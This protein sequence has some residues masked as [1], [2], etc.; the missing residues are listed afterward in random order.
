M[1]RS[2]D[3]PAMRP[4]P[5]ERYIFTEWKKARVNLDYHIEV[6]GRYYSVPH[7]LIGKQ[8]DVSFSEY[9]V[10]VLHKGERVANHAR[11]QGSGKRYQTQSAHMP[12]AHQ[13]MAEWTPE[14]IINW[15]ATVGEHTEKLIDALIVSKPH[16]QQA[17]RAVVG[18]IRLGKRY[19]NTRVEAACRR[20]Y[21]TN[22][23]SFSSVDS[24]LKHRLDELPLP[25]DAKQT[26]LPLMHDN[27]RG[28]G[29]Y[30]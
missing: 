17:F 14:R 5:V 9:V 1:F 22:A 15:A 29:Y 3:Y 28:A 30:H 25:Q 2:V 16:P 8:R 26:S 27:V 4:L 12:R 19:G 24:I 20:A 7:T 6:G 13:E 23:I 10:E 11:V 18:I 21:V